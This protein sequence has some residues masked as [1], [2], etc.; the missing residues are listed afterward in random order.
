MFRLTRE[1]RFAVN[2]GAADPPAPDDPAAAPPSNS[3]GGFPSL[4]GLGHYFALQ[5]TLAGDLEPKS[6]YLR[7]IKDID[8]AARRGAVPAGAAAVRDGPFAGGGRLAAG[9]FDLLKGA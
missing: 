6:Q 5:V 2:A 7:N 8:A 9:L 1:V 3:Y 4:T